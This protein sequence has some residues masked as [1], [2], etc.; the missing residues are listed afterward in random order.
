MVHVRSCESITETK[1]TLKQTFQI[2]KP[3]R[4]SHPQ[5]IIFQHLNPRNP[6]EGNHGR[7]IRRGLRLRELLG[8]LVQVGHSNARMYLDKLGRHTSTNQFL[9]IMECPVLKEVK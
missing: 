3:Q 2:W 8:I 4:S 6:T 5:P 1:L 9:V 7:N